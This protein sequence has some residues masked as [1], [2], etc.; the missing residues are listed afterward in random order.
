M[1]DRQFDELSKHLSTGLSR[2]GILRLLGGVGAAGISAASVLLPAEA[3]KKRARKKNNH[4]GHDKNDNDDN[5]AAAQ[6]AQAE[7]RKAKGKG[8][9]GKGKGKKKHKNTQGSAQPQNQVNI[10]GSGTCPTG[11][12]LLCH[13]GSGSNYTEVCSDASSCG[14]HAND[15]HDCICQPTSLHCDGGGTIQSCDSINV[16]CGV[17]GGDNVCTACASGT[18]RCGPNCCSSSQTCCDGT[19]VATNSLCGGVCGNVCKDD[20]TC[21]D[22]E[23]VADEDLCGGVCGNI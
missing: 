5:A 17:K 7:A 20:E 19:C 8:K 9:K 4:K 18:T 2:K 14:G 12:I 1:D 21:C 15:E 22:D 6:S 23:C 10:Q 11:K 16:A 13:S 3:K